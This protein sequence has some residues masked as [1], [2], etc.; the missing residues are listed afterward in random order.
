MDRASVTVI[1]CDAAGRINSV[2]GEI[3]KF[4]QDFS[5]SPQLLGRQC[6]DVFKEIPQ[7][8]DWLESE[9][10]SRESAINASQQLSLA[11][12]QGLLQAHLLSLKSD[13]QQGG[14][15]LLLIAQLDSP[16][17]SEQ[18]NSSCSSTLLSQ[19]LRH[20]LKN[21]LGG[22]KLYATFLKRRLSHDAALVEPVE[23]I[24]AGIDAL[25]AQISQMRFE[26]KS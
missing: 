2:G 8:T 9:M 19:R 16:Q 26:E 4:T 11:S 22:M 18:P 20:D 7:L 12:G 23:K 5:I 24:I 3:E 17:K 25:T 21:Q 14:F 13:G 10:R 15:I 6:A 1:A